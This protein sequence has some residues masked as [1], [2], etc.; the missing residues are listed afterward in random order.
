M[1][2]FV[3]VFFLLE[4]LFLRARTAFSLSKH[5]SFPL[6]VGTTPFLR[7]A[8][9]AH[10]AFHMQEV[11]FFSFGAPPPMPLLKSLA[12][13]FSAGTTGM[14]SITSVSMER[15]VPSCD[16]GLPR[17]SDLPLTCEIRGNLLLRRGRLTLV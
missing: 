7:R 6:G 17:S 10:V 8:H 3:S 16:E 4:G 9:Q 14:R 11:L 2:F 15:I 1:P 12:F 5:L 13:P